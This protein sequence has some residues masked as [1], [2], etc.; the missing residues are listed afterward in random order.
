MSV[1]TQKDESV[2]IN[3]LGGLIAATVVAVTWAF[4][5]ALL[6][7]LLASELHTGLGYWAAWR[8]AALAG[9]LLYT[10]AAASRVGRA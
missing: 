4:P 8:I 7:M 9:L 2:I 3:W 6:L 10:I 1:S 5:S